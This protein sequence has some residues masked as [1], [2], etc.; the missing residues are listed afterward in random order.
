M[1]ENLTGTTSTDNQPKVLNIYFTNSSLANVRYLNRAGNS[2]F[3]RSGMMFV[4]D[5]VLV[6]ACQLASWWRLTEHGVKLLWIEVPLPPWCLVTFGLGVVGV[7]E[8]W[9][10]PKR[11]QHPQHAPAPKDKVRWINNDYNR[12]ICLCCRKYTKQNTFS[13]KSQSETSEINPQR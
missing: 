4:L 2:V 10:C 5:D 8:L 6:M 7:V 9:F 13:L 11:V 1:V 3:G 12:V